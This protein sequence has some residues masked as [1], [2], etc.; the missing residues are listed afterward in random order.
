MKKRIKYIIIVGVIV[1]L[2]SVLLIR[3]ASL[4]MLVE[5]T[6][7]MANPTPGFLPD[8][9]I[10]TP[11]PIPVGSVAATVTPTQVTTT[12]W[13]H[14]G[15]GRS[16]RQNIPSSG[17]SIAVDGQETWDKTY[18]GNLSN[19]MPGGIKQIELMITNTGAETA[20]IWMRIIITDENGGEPRFYGYAS[21]EPEYEECGGG[22][23]LTGRP[24][25]LG[26]TERCD[27]SNHTIYDLISDGVLVVSQTPLNEVHNRWKYLGKLDT[28]KSMDV[29][30]HYQLQSEVSNWAQGDI[31]RFDMEIY[32]V[33]LDGLDPVCD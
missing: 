23:D 30:Q 31:V 15:G 18:S 9:P 8:E 4:S 3:L 7:T 1:A 11:I 6:K 29:M 5:V 20:N 2:S 13:Q 24:T 16:T 19:M 26:Y 25:G 27:I 17:V 28:D 32:A 22:F 12:G 21:S 33:S 10:A 14:G